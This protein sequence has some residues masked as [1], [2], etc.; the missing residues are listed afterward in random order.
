MEDP[1]QSLSRVTLEVHGRWVDRPFTSDMSTDGARKM[2]FN[3]VVLEDFMRDEMAAGRDP[4]AGVITMALECDA[5][6]G[7]LDT[8]H[9]ERLRAEPSEAKNWGGTEG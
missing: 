9:A 1:E 2:E 3:I 4:L 7:D 5:Q 6:T 8:F